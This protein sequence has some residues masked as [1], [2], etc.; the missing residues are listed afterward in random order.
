MVSIAMCVNICYYLRAP[1]NC[2]LE[3]IGIRTRFVCLS[4]FCIYSLPRLCLPL[5]NPILSSHGEWI[6]YHYYYYFIE[7]CKINILLI[8]IYTTIIRMACRLVVLSTHWLP[9]SMP[10][11]SRQLLFLLIGFISI[12]SSTTPRHPPLRIIIQSANPPLSLI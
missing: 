8:D 7:K 11:T 3:L 9:L 2:P 4:V 12:H 1:L 5:F 10:T 6:G